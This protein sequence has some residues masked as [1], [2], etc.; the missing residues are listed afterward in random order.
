MGR[1][2][3]NPGEFKKISIFIENI[4]YFYDF[5]KNDENNINE[6]GED[7]KRYNLTEEDLNYTDF[8]AKLRDRIINEV[9]KDEEE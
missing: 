6:I 8:R 9:L 3:K 4:D 7:L 2:S 1:P 5:I